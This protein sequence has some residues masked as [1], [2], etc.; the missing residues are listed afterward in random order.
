[1]PYLLGS[2]GDPSVSSYT[3]LVRKREEERRNFSNPK[4]K[5]MKAAA[6]CL[7]ALVGRRRLVGDLAGDLVTRLDDWS[8]RRDTLA[9]ARAHHDHA[10]RRAAEPLH[11]GHRHPDHR[12][13][14]RDQHHLVA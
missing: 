1:M 14:G 7:S 2:L 9:I 8:E 6:S 13:A 12:A 10:V 11:L 4:A 3:A 5:P